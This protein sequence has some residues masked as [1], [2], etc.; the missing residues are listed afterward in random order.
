MLKRLLLRSALELLVVPRRSRRCLEQRTATARVAVGEV[1]L[2]LV[3]RDLEEAALDAVVE[4]GAAEDELAEP[5]DERLP[6]ARRERFPVA[7]EVAPELGARRLDQAGGD[8]FDEVAALV[9]VQL[10]VADHAEPHGRRGDA[11]LEVAR[12]EPE[13]V[14]LE[15]DVVVVPRAV[16]AFGHRDSG[17][18]RGYGAPDDSRVCLRP[19]EHA[20]ARLARPL[21]RHPRGDA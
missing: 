9:L 6:L 13:A 19:R 18:A 21:A 14:V 5:V 1:S 20:A 2:L 7:H 8:E 12:V 3:P 10:V 15:L 11:L 16:V 4:P 17:Y